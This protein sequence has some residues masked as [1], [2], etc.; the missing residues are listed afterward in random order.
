[1]L[2]YGRKKQDPSRR[3]CINCQHFLV[4]IDPKSGWG[5]CEIAKNSGVFKNHSKHATYNAMHSNAR[6]YCQTGC[7]KRFKN[8]NEGET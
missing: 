7:K 1:M 6:Y 4:D 8:A 2:R 3:I 5:E